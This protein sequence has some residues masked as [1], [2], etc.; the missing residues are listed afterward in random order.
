TGVV[1]RSGTADSGTSGIGSGADNSSGSVGGTG[2]TSGMDTRARDRGP[3][4]GMDADLP[5]TA[6]AAGG[7][8][9]RGSMEALQREDRMR[10]EQHRRSMER[11]GGAL[12][13]A[14]P[15]EGSV[16]R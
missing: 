9:R 4:T 3:G 13:G 7:M 14:T 6:R 1:P 5:G 2:G 11:Q 8:N 16:Y 12:R 15:P 10:A